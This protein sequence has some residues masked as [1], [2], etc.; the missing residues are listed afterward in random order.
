MSAS[1]YQA[2]GALSA[3]ARSPD[4]ISENRAPALVR[5]FK[6]QDLSLSAVLRNNFRSG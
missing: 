5:G 4:L 6:E 1:L 2:A 3:N